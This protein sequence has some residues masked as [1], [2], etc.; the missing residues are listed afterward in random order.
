L[1]LLVCALAAA[2]GFGMGPNDTR[3]VR[4]FADA[5]RGWQREPDYRAVTQE[6]VTLGVDAMQSRLC[7]VSAGHVVMGFRSLPGLPEHL[8]VSDTSAAHYSA[9][10]RGELSAYLHLSS[11]QGVADGI[12]LIEQLGRREPLA[13]ADIVA[14][15]AGFRLP[16]PTV[17]DAGA[18]A[19]V[20]RL[21][22][23]VDAGNPFLVRGDVSTSLLS[24]IEGNLA[25]MTR[26]EQAAAFARFDAH[27][28]ATDPELW[29]SKQVS[30]FLAGIWAQGYGQIY[31]DGI[32]GFF[33]IQR[34]AR[35]VFFLALAAALLLLARGRLKRT[36]AA[37]SPDAPPQSSA[38][39][40]PG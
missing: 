11:E 40:K 13:D 2:V 31:L 20:R 8:A 33:R 34:G 37:P 18:I 29:R 35:I 24:A 9:F 21:L 23:D 4:A 25:T 1:A 30:D 16:V 28:R 22:A 19:G 17:T 27:V 15:L 38:A 7:G 6:Y 32:E 10:S 14:F 26:A 36:S 39:A 12:A 5:V 3:R